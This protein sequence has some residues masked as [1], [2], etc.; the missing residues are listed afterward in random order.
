MVTVRWMSSVFRQVWSPNIS[1]ERGI[2]VE[3]RSIQPA[4]PRS[5]LHDK[6]KFEPAAR[7][8]NLNAPLTCNLRQNILPALYREAPEFYE[9]T[10]IRELAQN[11]CE[12]GR[13]HH[14]PPDLMYRAFEVLP[15]MV[16]TPAPVSAKSRMAKRKRCILKRWL[17][18]STPT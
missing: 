2:I 9:N 16:M 8:L 1:D 4:A 7:S 15:K 3:N 10:R 13:E 12:T 17:V 6:P 11:I 18:A 5:A 14:N